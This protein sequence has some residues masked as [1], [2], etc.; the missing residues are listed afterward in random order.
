MLQQVLG[1][2]QFETDDFASTEDW[3]RRPIFSASLFPVENEAC[4]SHRLVSHVNID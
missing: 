4:I 1:D 2:F 3:L